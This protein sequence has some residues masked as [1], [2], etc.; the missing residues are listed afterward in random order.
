[1][2]E[3]MRRVILL[4]SGRQGDMPDGTTV[5][6]AAHRLGV[7]L[8]ALC[9]GKQRCAKCLVCL[10]MGSF[11]K[12]GIISQA[13]HLTAPEAAETAYAAAHGIDLRTTRMACAARIAGDVLISVPET[14]LARKQVFRKAAGDVSIELAPAVRM[15]CVEVERATLGSPGDWQR[16]QTALDAACGLRDLRIDLHALKTLQAALRGGNWTVTVTIWQGCE[17]IRVEPGYAE[18]LYG[19][20]VDIGSTTVV[21][22]L[23]DLLTG[24]VVATESVMN[25]QV[26][27]GEDIMSR[28]SYAV[29]PGGAGRMH[30]SIITALN[31]VMT[32][33]A[34]R[35][36]MDAH[37]I[38]ELV[39][40]GNSVMSHLFLGLDPHELGRM[41]FALSSDDALDLTAHE[42]GLKAAHPG[43]RVHL[44]PSIAAYVGA[45]TVGVLLACTVPDD[46]IT[47]IVDIG[48]NAEIVLAAAGALLASSSPTGPAFE[49]AQ[50]SHGQRASAGAIERFRYDA[51]SGRARYKV[52]GDPRWSDELPAGETLAPTGI[53]GSGMIEIVAELFRGGVVAASGRLA[54][55]GF[56]RVRVNGN[57]R[58]FVVANA[59]ETASGRAI[60]V[61]QHDIRAIQLAKAA[62]YAGARLL[63]EQGGVDHI[64]RIK[65]AGAF[66]SYIDPL[67]AMRI[68]LIPDCDLSRVEAIGNAA[69]DGARL[70]LLNAEQRERART[71][72]RRVEYV[73]TA[74]H[75]RFQ[76]CF[77]DALALPHARDVFPHAAS[78][79]LI[80]FTETGK[81]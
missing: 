41:P 40:V 35:A 9:G 80:P 23:C 2:T 15:V 19:M 61:T 60:V 72:A 39:V 53:C 71:L 79:P 62:L 22:Y 77:V 1:M 4:P 5:L 50:I 74:A 29:E 17:V 12:H 59:D 47:L 36:G 33:A 34:A 28:I 21:G 16:L 31:E 64:D 37:E 58:E 56:D 27:Y 38:S 45:D 30:H 25:P 66:G 63:M 52:V 43:A 69:G 44:L 7:E 81:P 78:E 65:L 76:D 32:N 20:A 75:P 51:D 8:E 26:R 68:G 18:S 24:E 73:E 11:P 3:P 48:T 10:E 46:E 54:P 49:G 57:S 13:Q 42:L 55:E 67:F 6:D 70:A 14:S